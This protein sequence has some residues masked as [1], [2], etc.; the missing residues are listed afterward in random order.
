MIQVV[1]ALIFNGSRFLICQRPRQKARGL[2]WEFVGGKVEL[3][4]TRQSALIRECKEELGV[5]IRVG[6][7]FLQ[8]DH[9]YPDLTIHLSV[10]HAQI[11]SGTIQKLE[12]EDIRWIEPS[13]IPQYK[14]CPAD[15]DILELIRIRNQLQENADC[16]YK[17]FI[18]RI[19]PTV[20]ADS[21]IGVRVPI[22]R[23]VA[24]SISPDSAF[25]QNQ[26]PHRYYEENYLHGIVISGMKDFGKTVHALNRFIPH[27]DNWAVCDMIAP[28]SFVKHP[29]SLID[30][31]AHWLNSEH[32]YSQRFAVSMLMKYYLDADFQPE[33]M[34][35]VASIK[36]DEY[37]VN[38]MRAW[39]FATALDKQYCAALDYLLHDRL[40]V[41][42]HNKAIQKAVESYRIDAERKNYLRSIKR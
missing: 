39:Y 6:E 40:D 8:L 26:L 24:K 18:E 35:W 38:M 34:Q 17:S 12:H 11:V 21:I 2:Q 33:Y 22:L 28:K 4:E 31:I 14:F 25:I 42:T 1:A 19:V 9:A 32:P 5:E 15:A 13:E 29:D 3:G 37:Y 7:L 30:S 16:E 23:K 36:S 20:P 27:M 41:W 10:F